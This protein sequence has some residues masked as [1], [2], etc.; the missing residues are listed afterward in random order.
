M[1][2]SSFKKVTSPVRMPEAIVRQIEEKFFLGQLTAGQTLPPEKELMKR[3]GVGRNTM[4]EALRILEHSGLI[5]VKQGSRR[6]PV[7]TRLTNEF[8]SDSLTRALRMRGVSPGDLSQFRLV[9]EPAIAESVAAKKDIDP[10]LLLQMETSISE[11]KKLY[12]VNQVTAYANMDFH[13]LLALATENPMFGIILGTLRAGFNLVSPPPE[14]Q[15][16]SIKYHQKILN[17]IKRKDPVEARRQMQQH[18]IRMA[19]SVPVGLWQ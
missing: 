16:E 3:F 17:A 15:V 14:S 6:G 18:L 8:V 7:I 1:S 2:L 11:V 10:E 4:R 13:V 9:I 12:E 5:K 19:K